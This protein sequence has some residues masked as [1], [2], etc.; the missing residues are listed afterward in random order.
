MSDRFSLDG[1]V[2]IVTGG[3]TGIGRGSA[4]ALA[5]HGAHLVLAARRSEPLRSTAKDIEA[6]GRRALPVSADVTKPEECQRIVDTTLAEFGRLD[7]LVNCAGG[8]TTKPLSRWTQDEWRQV[9]AL[10]LDSVWFLSRAASVPML[11]QS[12]GSIVNI[13]SGASLLAMASAAPY[14]A[15]KAGVNNLTGSMAAAWTPKGV[16]VNAIAV[17][18]VRTA[19][20]IDDAARYALDPESFGASNASGRLGDPEEIG[21]VVLFFASDAAS[22]CSGQTLYVHGG[23]GPAGV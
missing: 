13:S 5:E 11:A 18:A 21:N 10:N 2:A 19:S 14:G 15:A 12:S 22:F 4:L 20:L 9:M 23:P 17:G 1:R 3:G 7:I 6:M 8:A 16:R